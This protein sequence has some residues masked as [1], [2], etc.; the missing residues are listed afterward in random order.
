MIDNSFWSRVKKLL[1]AGKITQ[2]QLARQIG[3][4]VSTLEGWIF[5]DRIPILYNALKIA[6]VLG[7]T[8]E[9]LAYGRDR[10]IAGKRS[11]EPASRHTRQAAL[12]IS[13]LAR[14]IQ[15]VA[16]GINNKKPVKNVPFKREENKNEKLPV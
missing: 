6:G 12:R 11:K 2:A 13:D 1:K 16:D 10:T 4:S 8:V 15:N 3:I 7:V 5:Y 14:Q 9:F